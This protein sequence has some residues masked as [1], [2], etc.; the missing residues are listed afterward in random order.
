MALVLSE[1]AAGKKMEYRLLSLNDSQ[2]LHR[3]RI[4]ECEY[5]FTGAARG[6]ARFVASALKAARRRPKLV[7]ATHPNLAPIVRAMSLIA[8]RMKSIIC[9][10]GVEVWEPLSRM[11]RRA[12][13]R[14]T[15]VLAP[16]RATAESL[17]S[18]QG[19]A[20]EKIRVLPWG[21]DPDFETR[22]AG[23]PAASLPADFPKG[24]VILT[25]GRWLASERYKGMDTLIK[26]LPRLLLLYP[27]LQ[28]ALVGSGDD[29]EWLENIAH[30]NGVQRHVRFLS[31]ITYAELSACY[32]ASELFALPSRGEGFGFV[33]LEAMA[34]GKP[35]I[36]GAHGGAPEVI[37]D[38]VTGYLVPHGDTLQLAT[39]IGALLASPEL[40][41]QMGARGRER[42]E[43]EF[44]FNVFAKALKKIL[45]ELCGS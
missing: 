13:R 40:A 18:V 34:W 9:T 5:V 8:P 27:D 37:Q 44:R 20:E 35:V 7:L 26:T 39:S 22:I 23:E 38:G 16:S 17:V 33:Y 10:H 2:E 12:L 45:R 11:R 3:M 43:K 1:Y 29:R 42:V 14:A 32:A 24:R 19:V 21:L 15:V 30:V 41:R 25:V 31:D 36:G 6:K 28:L 4:G